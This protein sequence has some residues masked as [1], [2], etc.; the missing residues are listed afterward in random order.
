[1][2]GTVVGVGKDVWSLKVGDHVA[3]I[4]HG[5]AYPGEGA[6]AEYAKAPAELV[7]A[8][9]E[10]TLT[11][12]ESS[13]YNVA[14]VCLACSVRRM[15]HRTLPRFL[16]PVQM[17]YHTE[18]LALVEPPEKVSTE[19]WVLIYG[20]SCQFPSPSVDTRPT[21]Y[22]STAAVGQFAIQFAR[23]S[24]YKVVTTASPHNH[25]LV[26]SLGA[27]VVLDYHDSNIVDQIKGATGNTLKVAFDTISEKDTQRICAAALG[28]DGGKLGVILGPQWEAIGRSD[29]KVSCECFARRSPFLTDP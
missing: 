17:F 4:K 11:F 28:P 8:I 22:V 14:C 10:N 13:T 1:M 19:E 16:T 26:R 7:W 15:A 27:D 3:T 6:F 12:E 18:N 20:G 29:V 9:P 21:T 24:G 23:L 25:D 5:S 2:S